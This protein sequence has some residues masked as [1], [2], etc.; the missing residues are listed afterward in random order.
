VCD[1][2]Q[3]ERSLGL[4]RAFA[5]VGED[6]TVGGGGG[7]VGGGWGT[8]W[9]L[10]AKPEWGPGGGT[11]GGNEINGKNFRREYSWPRKIGYLFPPF[12]RANWV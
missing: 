3:Q 4:K 10:P 9:H 2:G 5:L 11:R 8:R 6:A 7:G 12:A 1:D